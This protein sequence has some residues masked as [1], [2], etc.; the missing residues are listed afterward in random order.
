[1]YY[2]YFGLKEEARSSPSLSGSGK[3]YLLF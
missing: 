2:N 1:M 3:T